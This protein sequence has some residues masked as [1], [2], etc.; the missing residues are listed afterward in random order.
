MKTFF[1]AAAFS[2]G[3]AFAGV[4]Y[5]TSQATPIINEARLETLGAWCDAGE[6]EACRLLAVETRGQCA[7]PAGSG[8]QY[9]STTMK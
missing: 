6:P 1:L 4:W 8:C 9:D 2:C 5:A 7:G 3:A